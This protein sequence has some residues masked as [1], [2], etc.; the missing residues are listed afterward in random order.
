MCIA[1]TIAPERRSKGKMDQVQTFFAYSCVAV[2]VRH[3]FEIGT[4]DEEH[5]CR[6]ELRA[7]PEFVHRGTESASQMFITDRP[8][9]RADLFDL[10]DEAPG[11]HRRA[12]YHPACRYTEPCDRVWDEALSADPRQWIIDRLRNLTETLD[13]RTRTELHLASD[14]RGVLQDL[15]AIQQAITRRM[16]DACR[17]PQVCVAQTVDVRYVVP[18]MFSEFRNVGRG[19]DPR[20]DASTWADVVARRRS[21]DD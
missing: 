12:H 8:L 4:N 11:N 13:E 2:V 14:Q 9:W 1:D 18:A 15:D 17:S 10:V 16:G 19:I 7:L 6:V 5:G 20:E 3:W 21:R